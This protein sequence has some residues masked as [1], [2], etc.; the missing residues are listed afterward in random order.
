MREE[1]KILVDDVGLSSLPR[2]KSLRLKMNRN[3]YM[4]GVI[5]YLRTA[6][7]SLRVLDLS[8]NE[9]SKPTLINVLSSTRY[10]QLETLLL[11]N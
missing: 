11:N 7:L 4:D 5:R 9:L 1:T 3:N 8:D 10:L 2:L 6:A